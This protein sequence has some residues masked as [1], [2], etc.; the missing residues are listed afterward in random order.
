MEKLLNGKFDSVVELKNF[1]KQIADLSFKVDYEKIESMIS[2]RQKLMDKVSAIDAE[3]AD[4]KNEHRNCPE[5][6]EAKIISKKIKEIIAEII[7]MDK[8]IRKNL[9]DEMKIVNVNLNKP[10]KAAGSLNFKA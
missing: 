4:Y 10:E 3:I 6:D 1:T 8:T 9:N 2:D 5:S 7:E